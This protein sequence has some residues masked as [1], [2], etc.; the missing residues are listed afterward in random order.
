MNNQKALHKL[1][2]A[3]S[4][5]LRLKRQVKNKRKKSQTNV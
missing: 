1:S 5:F 4:P 3:I 2:G